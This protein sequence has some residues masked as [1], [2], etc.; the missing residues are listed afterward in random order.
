MV[1]ANPMYVCMHMLQ[2]LL[3]HPALHIQ[4]NRQQH[5][6]YTQHFF[7]YVCVRMLQELLGHPVVDVNVQNNR[8]KT[9]LGMAKAGKEGK[10]VVEMLKEAAKQREVC[11]LMSVMM[12]VWL[13][14][15]KSQ[16]L[17]YRFHAFV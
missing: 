12:C 5:Q 4:D 8:G 15:C 14:K 1:L 10:L 6:F 17:S 13:C 9:A 2:E 11:V 7:V 16:V 3:G